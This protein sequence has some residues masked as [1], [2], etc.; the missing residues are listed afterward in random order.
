MEKLVLGI[1]VGTTGIKINLYSS[2][3]FLVA[4]KY[5]EYEF[6]VSISNHVEIDPE[7]WWRSLLECLS[8]FS[9]RG[10]TENIGSIGIS[11]ANSMVLLG[12]TGKPLV[13][14]ILQLDK[15]G[16]EYVKAIK[17]ELGEDYIFQ[18]VGNRVHPG[19]LWA[20][21]L[22]WIK[23][24]NAGLL[25]NAKF[26]CNPCSYLILRLT[27]V[28]SMDYSRATTT[29]MYDIRKKKWDSR[30]C[31][32]FG[33]N[34]D[35]LPKVTPS[36]SVIGETLELE[37]ILPAGIPV[38]AGVMDSIAVMH[39][40]ASNKNNKFC[41]LVLGSLGRFCFY[42]EKLD[43]RFI[44]TLSST[45]DKFVQMTPVNNVGLAF[46]WI[47]NILYTDVYKSNNLY[48]EMDA[49]AS[50][51]STGSEGLYFLPYLTGESSPKWDGSVKSSFIGLTIRHTRGHL[52]KAVMEGICYALLENYEI[53]LDDLALSFD[54][55]RVTGGCS[56]SKVW[57][58][59][60]CD[61]LGVGLVVPNE[62][63]LEPKGAFLLASSGIGLDIKIEYNSKNQTYD[64]Y[65]PDMQTHR[66]YLDLFKNFKS[67]CNVIDF[68][69]IDN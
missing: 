5:R 7:L 49:L 27:G 51:I 47:K 44:T 50:K 35:R 22:K 42:T 33:V 8:E 37:N 23:E 63:D 68:N 65:T 25:K 17:N 61:M 1:D 19:L 46:K 6:S 10:Y 12:E 39:S 67:L 13:P 56:S 62:K 16:S 58:Q 29:M 15:R 45:G 54:E 21:T 18:T 2:K 26:F 64:Y 41:L 31:D 24:N 66:L 57:M 60:L 59:I 69:D 55:I 43:S 9:N 52:I 20:P 3:S 40:A 48:Q 34:V 14:A 30:I 53:M 32:Y 4:S 28:Y 11:C 36:N 38:I